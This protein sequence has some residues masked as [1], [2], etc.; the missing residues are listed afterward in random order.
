MVCSREVDIEINC[1]PCVSTQRVRADGAPYVTNLAS[2]FV[3]A[4]LHRRRD[5]VPQSPEWTL[6]DEV[7]LGI[8][9]LSRVLSIGAVALLAAGEA[10]A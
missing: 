5:D 8:I 1:Q 2:S 3:T 4:S 10:P 7:E 6:P 9:S